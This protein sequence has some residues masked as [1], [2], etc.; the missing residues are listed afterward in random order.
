MMLQTSP[1]MQPCIR[2]SMRVKQAVCLQEQNRFGNLPAIIDHRRRVV[3][4]ILDNRV[5]THAEY[6]EK[7]RRKKSSQKILK[8]SM[9]D[10]VI[11]VAQL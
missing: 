4:N 6:M 1:G 11:R 5:C 7:Q 8:Q 9:K 3:D 10:D 2:P